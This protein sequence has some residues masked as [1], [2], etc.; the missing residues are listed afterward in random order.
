M[1]PIPLAAS[2]P[3][4][5]GR[6]TLGGGRG[7]LP[8]CTALLGSLLLLFVSPSSGATTEFAAIDASKV[9]RGRYVISIS[10][11][12]DCHTR[13]FAESEGKVPESQWL[14]GD[15]LGW[16]GPWG[17]TYPSNLRRLIAGLSEDQWVHLARN[18]Q[19]RPPMPWFNLRF[20]SEDDLRAVHHFVRYLGPSEDPVP[21]YLPPDRD[22]QPPYVT[23][24]S[25]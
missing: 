21:E 15:S 20:M 12:N 14:S 8:R 13:N 5:C 22:P 10:G 19:T 7:F 18:L 3:S 9:A 6:R 17:T 25:P 1:F 24:P 11:C 23:F 16:K 2:Q 4:S